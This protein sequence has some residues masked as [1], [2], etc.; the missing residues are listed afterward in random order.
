MKEYEFL[1][2]ECI[3]SGNS[4]IIITEDGEPILFKVSDNSKFMTSNIFA[5][6]IKEYVP[7]LHSFF[8]DIGDPDRRAILNEKEGDFAP[9]DFIMAQI[10]TMAR[11][12]K[13]AQITTKIRLS[14]AR[15]V[16]LPCE[17][18]AA[19]NISSKING[20]DLREYL[21]SLGESL[22]G[23]YSMI[24]RTQAAET[25]AEAVER[26]YKALC[27][28]WESIV[29]KTND[30]ISKGCVG[31]TYS[32]L[33][34]VNEILKYPL[35]SYTGVFVDTPEI[36]DIFKNNFKLLSNKVHYIPSR[37]FTAKSVD[38]V[39]YQLLGKVVHL[40]SGA[41]IVIEKT[42]ALTVVDVNTSKSSKSQVEVNFE[43][44]KEIMRQLR[45]R[46]IGGIIICDFIEMKNQSDKDELIQYMKS[47]ATVDPL[48]PE[49]LGLTKLG[50]ME[51]SR[52]RN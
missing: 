24:F 10:T 42:E 23:K 39:Q 12:K 49:I 2:R 35:S 38:N 19:V 32:R 20:A 22:G 5:A 7:H 25:S 15:I 18:K 44:A 6:R 13:G 28:V 46:D 17:S 40:K 11:G 33:P 47:L 3:I 9:G 29:N 27:E 36:A 21:K 1:K 52:K 30:L 14:G 48:K 26:E 37:I 31:L 45:L 4:E 8:V 34:V 16:L 43:A 41:N 50:L 51:I